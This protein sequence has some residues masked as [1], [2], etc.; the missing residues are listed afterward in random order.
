[1]YLTAILVAFSGLN[2]LAFSTL[3]S[4][5]S[6]EPQFAS[7]LIGQADIDNTSENS[8]TNNNIKEEIEKANQAL[9]QKDFLK[10]IARFKA[11]VEKLTDNKYAD[12][13]VL[14]YRKMGVAYTLENNFDEAIKNFNRALLENNKFKSKNSDL[15]TVRIKYSMARAFE[16]KGDFDNAIN[17]SQSALDLAREKLGDSQYLLRRLMSLKSELYLAHIAEKLNVSNKDETP[18]DKSHKKYN[19]EHQLIGKV[20]SQDYF[21]AKGLISE[22]PSLDTTHL[23]KRRVR[24]ARAR[25]KV[26]LSG[27]RDIKAEITRKLMQYGT[28]GVSIKKDVEGRPW[29]VRFVLKDGA[30]ARAGVRKGD[31][32][33]SI[34]GHPIKNIPITSIYHMAYGRRGEVRTLGIRRK[35]KKRYVRVRLISVYDIGF[36]PTEYL[37]YYWFLLYNGYITKKQFAHLAKPYEK[38]LR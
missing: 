10:A 35:G 18:E 17:T 28:F 24:Y 21:K 26:A 5:I 27:K 38:Y 12:K 2:T 6:L 32:I 3:P 9:E 31:I 19:L 16:A 11:I 37:E 30:G 20:S 36:K 15:N 29:H 33:N 22:V 4:S 14:C 13:R 25:K 8:D 7:T 34:D 1:M 23:R